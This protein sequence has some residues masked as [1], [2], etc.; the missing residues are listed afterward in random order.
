MAL[1]NIVDNYDCYDERPDVFIRTPGLTVPII[2]L[3]PK[4]Q[5]QQQCIQ[6]TKLKC[7]GLH[8]LYIRGS[9]LYDN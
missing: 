1:S 4:Q 9:I 5:K 8:L 3:L 6:Y 2:Y 7:K